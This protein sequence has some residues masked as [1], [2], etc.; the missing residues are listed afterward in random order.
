LPAIPRN[1]RPVARA[2]FLEEASIRRRE[3]RWE[4]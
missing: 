1:P 3:M 2:L 4:S